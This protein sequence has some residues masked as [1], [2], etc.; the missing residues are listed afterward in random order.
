[1]VNVNVPVQTAEV[2][3]RERF[4]G[5]FEYTHRKNTFNLTVFL[6]NREFQLS[7][8]EEEAKGVELSWLWEINRKMDSRLRLA[9]SSNDS[10]RDRIQNVG[11]RNQDFSVLEYRLTKKINP[12]LDAN[13]GYR[14][15]DAN[16]SIASES[17]TENR[18]FVSV[19]KRF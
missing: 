10:V 13:I 14:Y 17:Y 3:I 4:N 11:D 18:I 15:V 19:S 16:S 12:G 2:L 5:A 1:M 8:R 7:G 6:E 9:L